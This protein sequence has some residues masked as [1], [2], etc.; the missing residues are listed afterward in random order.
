VRR[1]VGKARELV[2]D[3]WLAPTS[4]MFVVVLWRVDERIEAPGAE[5][6]DSIE[7]RRV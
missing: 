6:S 5:K 3:V 1:E 7:A 4:A 2:V